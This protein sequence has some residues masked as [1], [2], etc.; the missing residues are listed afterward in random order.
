[1]E[2]D[3]RKVEGGKKREVEGTWIIIDRKYAATGSPYRYEPS[4]M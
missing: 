3:K 2:E 1:M 4:E